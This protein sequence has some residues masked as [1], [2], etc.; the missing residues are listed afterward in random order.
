MNVV[1]LRKFVVIAIGVYGM[2]LGASYATSE[3][4][5]PQYGSLQAHE[6]ASPEPAHLEGSPEHNHEHSMVEVPADQPLPRVNL[7]AHPDAQQGW[8]LETQ[9]T[10]FRFAPEKVNQA[11]ALTEGHAHLYIDAVKVTRLYGNWYYLKELPPGSH[12]ITVSLNTNQHETLAHNGQPIQAT[13]V[14]ES[15]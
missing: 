2:F 6:P 9:V 11:G 1:I 12:Q 3:A 4:S 7:I 8:N 13:V 15:P 5:M 14:V 10:N